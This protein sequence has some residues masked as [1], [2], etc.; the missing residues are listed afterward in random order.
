MK[1]VVAERPQTELLQTKFSFFLASEAHP[2]A[3]L[4]IG[5]KLER[6]WQT[7]DIDDELG[8]QVGMAYLAIVIL[9]H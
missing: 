7:H 9:I 1:F 6:F 4:P 5:T 2:L 8:T 3:Q